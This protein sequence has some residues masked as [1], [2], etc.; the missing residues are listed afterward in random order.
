MKKIA[1]LVLL[2]LVAGCV[3]SFQLLKSGDTKMW[4]SY[5]VAVS[6]DINE[7]KSEE[8]VV[9]TQYGPIL[10]AIRF[11]KPVDNNG[12]ISFPYSPGQQDNAAKF[13]SNMSAEEIVE[14][15]RSG[16]TITGLIVTETSDLTPVKFGTKQGYQFDIN[17]STSDGAD[18]KARVLFTVDNDKLYIIDLTAQALHYFDYRAP[19]F[20]QTTASLQF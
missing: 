3:P 8:M 19:F 17:V 5:S 15:Y 4:K 18:Y 9:W 6:E 1:G 13:R 2:M 14:L 12:V 16:L 10:E 20:Q 11:R 7:L